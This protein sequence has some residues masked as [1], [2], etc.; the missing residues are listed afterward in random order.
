MELPD[1]V[2]SEP[3]LAS[4]CVVGVGAIDSSDKLTGLETS[5]VKYDDCTFSQLNHIMMR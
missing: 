1:S 2:S 4:C 3:V 5:T